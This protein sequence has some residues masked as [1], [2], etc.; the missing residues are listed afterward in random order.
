VEAAV[1]LNLHRRHLDDSQRQLVGAKI[2]NLKHGQR[3]DYT[4][5]Q[6]C[7]SVTQSDAAEMMNVSRRGV[8]MARTVL[9]SGAPE[10]VRIG[11]LLGGT[12]QGQRVDL[13]HSVATESLNKDERY[14]FR[15]LAEHADVVERGGTGPQWKE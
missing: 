9:D 12:S 6:T 11:Q 10:V 1:S 3:A 2:A 15:K 14:D 8:Q 5:A 13:E 4:D 7:A